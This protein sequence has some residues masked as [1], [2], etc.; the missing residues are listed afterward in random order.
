MLDTNALPFI[1]AYLRHLR[2]FPSEAP[3]AVA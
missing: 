2:I 1:C 3:Q